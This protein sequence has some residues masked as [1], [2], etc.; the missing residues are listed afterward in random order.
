MRIAGLLVTVFIA[1]AS[2]D[3]SGRRLK[4]NKDVVPAPVPLSNPGGNPS[5]YA[6]PV[7][8]P[9]PVAL[10]VAVPVPVALGVPQD[11]CQFITQL[12]TLDLACYTAVVHGLT[13]FN[14]QTFANKDFSC[15]ANSQSIIGLQNNL[16]AARLNYV[17][18]LIPILNKLTPVNQNCFSLT[19]SSFEFACEPTVYDAT[20]F[21]FIRYP[22]NRNL[23][24]DYVC[25]AP[26]AVLYDPNTFVTPT[27]PASNSNK[28]DFCTDVQIGATGL[29]AFG[30]YS[31]ASQCT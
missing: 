7:P 21:N 14:L 16:K 19:P 26:R 31:G 25:C 6:V 22:R 11:C 15:E 5:P 9:T 3:K 1:L 30:D 12:V 29:D 8:V 28:V 23:I 24:R 2:A 13:A 4:T 10:P 27:N 17:Q 20:T 18:F